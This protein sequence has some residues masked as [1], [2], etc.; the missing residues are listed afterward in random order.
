M[1]MTKW[2]RPFGDHSAKPLV[3][4]VLLTT[5]L[6]AA[7]SNLGVFDADGQRLGTESKD[8]KT[9]WLNRSWEKGGHQ[10]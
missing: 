4:K 3:H 6:A 2:W 7:G 10:R 1:P 8:G 5:F 9:L